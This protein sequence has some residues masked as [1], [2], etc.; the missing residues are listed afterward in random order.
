MHST[1]A[2]MTVYFFFLLLTSDDR[3]K[4]FFHKKN[5][6]VAVIPH[7]SPPSSLTGLIL[8][9]RFMSRAHRSRRV[10]HVCHANASINDPEGKTQTPGQTH[11]FRR[12]SPA[13]PQLFVRP[14]I[15]ISSSQRKQRANTNDDE[16]AHPGWYAYERDQVTETKRPEATISV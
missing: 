16:N 12:T 11:V 5:K 13:P 6:R 9:V 8:S 14:L 3:R 4:I 10:K 2:C 15:T 1:C 7:G